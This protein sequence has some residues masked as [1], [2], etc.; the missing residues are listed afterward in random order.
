MSG[1]GGHIFQACTCSQ[2]LKFFAKCHE[3]VMLGEWG[4]LNNFVISMSNPVELGVFDPD[5]FEVK[6][7]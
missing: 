1:G 3:T 2:E 6:Q 4:E 5:W 7:A